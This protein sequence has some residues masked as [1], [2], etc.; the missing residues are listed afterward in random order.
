[1]YRK[2][3][4]ETEIQSGERLL[5]QLDLAKI[6]VTAAFWQYADDDAEWRLVIV[7]PYVE[8]LGP[9]HL[10][11]SLGVML[12]NPSGAPI[13]IPMERIYLLGSHDVRYQ[14]VRTAALGAGLSVTGGPAR[15]VSG[16]D[17]YFYRVA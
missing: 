6:P 5:E 7:S 2:V 8:T 17:A 16:E 9:R 11:A 13:S 4:V 1:M 10:Y 14:Q 3:L 12:K 15:N